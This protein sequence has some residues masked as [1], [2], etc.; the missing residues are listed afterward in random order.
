MDFACVSTTIPIS[1]FSALASLYCL[2][3]QLGSKKTLLAR[4]QQASHRNIVKYRSIFEL[5]AYKFHSPSVGIKISWYCD[6]WVGLE[7]DFQTQPTQVHRTQ[8]VGGPAKSQEPNH[9]S[10]PIGFGAKT[11]AS[12][13]AGSV[14]D[15]KEERKPQNHCTSAVRNR[16]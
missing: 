11:Q 6:R 3:V 10:E 9:P 12:Y 15:I 13:V 16:T 4:K 14:A 2:H 8:W 5:P 7:A 1:G